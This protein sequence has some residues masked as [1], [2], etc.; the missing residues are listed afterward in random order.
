M[1]I[2]INIDIYSFLVYFLYC[3]GV[4]YCLACP[5]AEQ[6]GTEKIII[7]HRVHRL[8][9]DIFFY[10]IIPINCELNELSSKK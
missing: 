9:S 2:V 1:S 4:I 7:H 6:A 10:S 5:P 3:V 8:R